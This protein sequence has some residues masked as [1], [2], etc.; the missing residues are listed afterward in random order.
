[1]CKQTMFK[2]QSKNTQRW[3]AEYIDVSR[4]V[5]ALESVTPGE[6]WVEL[7][8]EGTSD[9]GGIRIEGLMN[10][11]EVKRRLDARVAPNLEI[12]AGGKEE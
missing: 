12:L 6:E 5:F 3:G 11:A 4:I 9:E 1:M 7:W 10:I 8:Y 2:W